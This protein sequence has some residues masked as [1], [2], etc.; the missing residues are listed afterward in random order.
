MSKLRERLALA[1]RRRTGGF[2]FAALREATSASRQ[3]TVIAEVLDADDAQVAAGS[4][5]DVLLA[6]GDPGR[7]PAIVAAAGDRPVGIRID[8]ATRADTAEAAA[9]GADFLLFT[10]KHTSAEALLETKLGYV[11]VLDEDF[12]DEDELKLLQ[13][14][15]LDAALVPAQPGHP[16]VRQQ[17]E[18]RRYVELTQTPLLLP[19]HG[20]VSAAT[21]ELWRDAGAYGVLVAV[22]AAADLPAVIASVDAVPPRRERRQQRD[23]ALLPGLGRGATP[24]PDDDEF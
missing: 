14:L 23:I 24:E 17:L 22:S 20:D 10:D 5:A 9:T 11:L 18:L 4:G 2:G 3:L 19:V 8:A 12:D 7:L 15:S 16:T 13:A 21:L 1:T 6:T